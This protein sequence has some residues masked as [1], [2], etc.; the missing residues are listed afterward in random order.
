MIW[1]VTS[2]LLYLGLLF[3]VKLVTR[4]TGS[5]KWWLIKRD[6]VTDVQKPL[7]SNT[8]LRS[9][10][11]R[12]KGCSVMKKDFLCPENPSSFEERG[13]EIQVQYP[14]MSMLMAWQWL[15]DA[16]SDCSC[17]V[18]QGCLLEVLPMPP[19]S[20]LHKIPSSCFLLFYSF[21]LWYFFITLENSHPCLWRPV[22]DF[23]PIQKSPFGKLQALLKM[24][25]TWILS[26][27]E[28]F[29]FNT[30]LLNIKVYRNIQTSKTK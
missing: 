28:Y 20:Y 29:F 11:D 23:T 14:W 21:F 9:C 22:F 2:K 17:N 27:V 19:E 13:T 6:A 25:G 7:C 16:V 1:K 26:C 18:I 24:W 10:A 4:I 30:S 8:L 5:E 15:V 3:G 12:L